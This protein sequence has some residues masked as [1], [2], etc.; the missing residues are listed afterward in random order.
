M[1][2][3]DCAVSNWDDSVARNQVEEC[4]HKNGVIE[5]IYRLLLLPYVGDIQIDSYLGALL[6]M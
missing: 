4:C 2:I 3:L 6:G 1:E 5:M